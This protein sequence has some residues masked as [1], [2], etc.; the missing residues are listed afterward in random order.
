MAEHDQAQ[1]RTERATARKQ[2]QSRERGQVARSREL[3]TVSVLVAAAVGL[4]AMGSNLLSGLAELMRNG[5]TAASVGVGDA[6]GL[7]ARL[8][9]AMLD[10]VTFLA[11]FFALMVVV[12][13]AAPLSLSGWS[14]SSKALAFKWEK[15]DPVKGLG[16]VF[17]WRGVVELAKALAKFA[18]V[19]GVAVLLLWRDADKL[20]G[21]SAEPLGQALRHLA[22]LLGWSFLTLSAVL[23][24]V[25]AA[26]VPFQLWD[27]ARQLRMT[28]QEVKD[29]HKET[30]GRPEVRARIRNLQ[31]EVS[32]R[33]MMEA[34]P[35]ADIVVTNPDHYSVALRYEPDRMRAPKVL[36]KGADQIAL[37]IRE[38]ATRHNVPIL[39][40]PP[41]AR[42][43][44][45]STKLDQE[46]PAGLYVAVAQVLAY[47]YQLRHY[48]DGD[49]EPPVPPQDPPIPDKFRDE[50]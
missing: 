36:A 41:L 25:A 7:A 20:V 17:A 12:A 24:L 6:S 49:G 28:R 21:L 43:L 15:L 22:H 34:V 14:F 1:E 26:D 4:L 38:V 33:R 16:R 46:I 35:D 44:Y 10:S 5:F 23:I 18:L 48:R 32:R 11:P 31:Q 27:H 50:A 19:A 8:E 40:S 42:A 37:R 47:V 13:L 29:E 39:S 2:Q 45:F 3:N 30:E 9:Q